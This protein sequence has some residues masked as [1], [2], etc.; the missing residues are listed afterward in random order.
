V[1]QKGIMFY[2]CGLKNQCNLRHFSSLT[3]H[4]W[5]LPLS[6]DDI[7]C[8]VGECL[9][10]WRLAMSSGFLCTWHRWRDGFKRFIK[11]YKVQSSNNREIKTFYDF[12]IFFWRARV[13]W[14]L[15]RLCRPFCIFEKWLDS[16]Q[17][18]SVASRCATNLAAHLPNLATHLPKRNHPS[19]YQLSHQSSFLFLATHLPS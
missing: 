12:C 11:R 18:A 2:G 19:P 14:P 3:T 4:L 8:A 9:H 17:K 16:N 13:C 1:R 7:V 15:L 6:N 5:Y 10:C